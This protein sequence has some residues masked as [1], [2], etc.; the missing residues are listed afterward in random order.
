MLYKLVLTF[1]FV[2]EILKCA[3]S[4]KLYFP[5]VLFIPLV[6]LKSGNKIQYVPVKGTVYYA[7]QDGS[8]YYVCG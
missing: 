8:H 3:L 2:D 5:A 7:V 1:Q 6:G 4:N